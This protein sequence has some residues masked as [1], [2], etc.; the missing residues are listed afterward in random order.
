MLLAFPPPRVRMY[1]RASVVAEKLHAMVK[2]GAINSR[3][4]DDHDIWFLASHGTFDFEEL[5]GAITA[6][7]L[8]R[9]TAVPKDIEGLGDEFK[10]T[11]VA[12]W[13]GFLRREPS[14]AKVDL[15]VVMERLRV[16]LLPCLLPDAVSQFPSHRTWDPMRGTWIASIQ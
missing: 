4:K 6:T 11:H 12:M 10:R 9:K 3:M 2:L 7:F 5:V 1:S 15:A 8:A 14:L 16:F 13:D